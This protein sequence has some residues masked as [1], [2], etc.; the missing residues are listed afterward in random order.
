MSIIRPTGIVA[1]TASAQPVFGTT[2]SALTALVPDAY[3]GNTLPGSNPSLTPVLVASTAIFRQGDTV[4]V[5]PAIG[6]WD[7]GTIAKITDATHMTI[8]GLTINHASGQYVILAEDAA[9]VHVRAIAAATVLYLGL[10]QTVGAASSTVFD[11]LATGAA[12][13]SST[14][15]TGGFNN[16]SEYWILGAAADTYLAYFTRK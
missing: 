11:S 5:G 15:P 8:Q 1:L 9:R 13:D 4:N 10:D 3:S 14:A 2:L 16:T 6:P 7:I 12:Y